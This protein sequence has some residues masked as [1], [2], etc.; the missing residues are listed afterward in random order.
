M[1]MW[2]FAI[3][4]HRSICGHAGSPG[5]MWMWASASVAQPECT[6]AVPLVPLESYWGGVTAS[7]PCPYGAHHLFLR[8][9]KAAYPALPEVSIA[10]G[11]TWQGEG[12]LWVYFDDSRADDAQTYPLIHRLTS[13]TSQVPSA[14]H[15]SAEV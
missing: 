7:L 3:Y 9:K 8:L 1:D 12:Y 15:G 11:K 10:Q 13:T 5:R 4:C 14:G 2:A 6:T